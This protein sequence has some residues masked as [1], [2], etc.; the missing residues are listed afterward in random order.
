MSTNYYLH[1]PPCLACKLTH[2]PYHIGMSA[3]GWCF[4]LHI[5]PAQGINDLF[6]VIKLCGAPGVVIKDEYDRV[7][8]LE[9]LTVII[10]VRK[11]ENLDKEWESPP[12]GYES[13]DR[14]HIANESE[15]GPNGLVRS[16]I[17]GVHCVKH[18]DGTWDCIVGEFS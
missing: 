7:I 8:P 1:R 10:S 2:P 18:G 6:D 9:E 13:W 17:D 14:F 11:A 4:A 3:H 12:S 16:K 15:R 5:E